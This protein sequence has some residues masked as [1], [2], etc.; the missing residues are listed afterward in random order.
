MW[1][2]NQTLQK[3]AKS[4]PMRILGNKAQ[5]RKIVYP[6]GLNPRKVTM[7]LTITATT[8]ISLGLILQIMY[9][10]T[11]LDNYLLYLDFL[12]NVDDELNIPSYFSS[13]ILLI[14]GT[15]LAAITFLKFSV[16]DK[17]RRHWLLL[18]CGFYYL[19]ADEMLT[20]HEQL[21]KPFKHLM[22]K[23]T[24]GIFTFAWVI[25]GLIIVG[26]LGV[27][28]IRFLAALP[29]VTRTNFMIAGFFFVGGSIGVEMLGAKYAESHG[30][31]NMGYALYTIVEESCEMFGVIIFIHALLSYI[32]NSYK[33]LTLNF[34]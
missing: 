24:S 21:N 29:K 18:T 8:I 12:F 7:F 10:T 15:L 30:M 1:P 34:E 33:E 20:L 14:A 26:F 11:D 22:G 13:V 6:I 25:P 23:E 4:R 5:E 31:L 32:K 9:Y 28:F 19:A 16:A 27:I 3:K 2:G 17:F